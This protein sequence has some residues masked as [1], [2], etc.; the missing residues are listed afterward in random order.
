MY[1]IEQLPTNLTKRV[2]HHGDHA[3]VHLDQHLEEVLAIVRPAAEAIKF[4][5]ADLTPDTTQVEFGIKLDA[6]AGAVVAQS[7]VTKGFRNG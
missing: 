7:G 4:T 2:T 6:E 1:E 3:V 5:V